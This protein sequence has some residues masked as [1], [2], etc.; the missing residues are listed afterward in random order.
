[1][2]AIVQK[3]KETLD[4]KLWGGRSLHIGE[5]IVLVVAFLVYWFR[6]KIG[7]KDLWA[8]AVVFVMM[9]LAFLIW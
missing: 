3:T 8:I 6:G 2:S 7:L 1:M 9:F 4:R 5:L